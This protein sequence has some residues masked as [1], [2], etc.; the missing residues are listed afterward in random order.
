VS[1]T[2]VTVTSVTEAVDALADLGER[3]APLAGA[4]WIMR[5]R[6]RGEPEKRVYISLAGIA[7]LAGVAVNGQLRAGALATHTDLSVLDGALAAVGEAASRS[8]FPAVRNVATLGGNLCARPFPEA[9]LLPALLA[10]EAK[11]RLAG[12]DGEHLLG[13]EEY[14]ASRESRPVAELITEVLAPAPGNRRSAYERLTVRGGGEYAIASVAVS[15]DLDDSGIV[16]GARVALGSVEDVARASAAGAAELVG[17]P[18]DP[19]AAERCGSAAAL[20]ATPREGLDAPGWYRAAVLPAL[21][22][23]AVARITRE[24]D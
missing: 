7:E 10:A 12:P 18:L 2:I 4:T 16:R 22:R 6:L 23:R 11:V 3:G 15:V 24:Q 20:E 21:V 8:A 13:V 1:A 14:M 9:D 19:A 17:G 5:G